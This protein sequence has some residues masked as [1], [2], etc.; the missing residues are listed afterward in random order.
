MTK[1]EPKTY[2]TAEAFRK[3]L[4]DRAQKRSRETGES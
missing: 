3:A 1:D 2:A 4:E